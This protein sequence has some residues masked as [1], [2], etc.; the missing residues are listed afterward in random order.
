MCIIKVAKW[1]DTHTHTHTH[2]HKVRLSWTEVRL[3]VLLYIGA[4]R[5]CVTG[6]VRSTSDMMCMRTDLI[7]LWQP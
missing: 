4:D 6:S 1:D 3:V 5:V 2:T 7:Y